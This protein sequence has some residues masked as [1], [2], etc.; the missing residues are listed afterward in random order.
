MHSHIRLA[1]VV[2]LIISPH[3]VFSIPA[4]RRRGT[5][6]ER[7]GDEAATPEERRRLIEEENEALGRECV[8]CAD[9]VTEPLAPFPCG[10]GSIGHNPVCTECRLNLRQPICP[11]CRTPIHA[12]VALNPPRRADVNV[13]NLPEYQKVLM[14]ITLTGLFQ[15]FLGISILVGPWGIHHA[16]VWISTLILGALT[17]GYIWDSRPSRIALVIVFAIA[18][19]EGFWVYSLVGETIMEQFGMGKGV[20][21][22]R[23][24]NLTI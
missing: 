13:E 6:P 21:S 24:R 22:K 20:S 12:R 10:H 17:C 23:D 19:A 15:F 9:E 5:F 3:W 4:R 1:L 2:I 18:V 7:N 16:A 11:I 14:L 8:A